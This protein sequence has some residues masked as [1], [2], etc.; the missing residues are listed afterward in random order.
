MEENMA[1]MIADLSGYTALTDTHGAHRAADIVDEFLS[2]VYQNLDGESILHEHSGDEVM[3]VSYSPDDLLKTA[4]QILLQ[5][6]I[7]QFP[8][9]HAGLHFG[10]VLKRN[11]RYFGTTINLAS[12]I[13]SQAEPG[14]LWSSLA[15]VSVIRDADIFEP[16]GNR[17]LKN[18][19]ELF[20]LFQYSPNSPVKNYVDPVCK[21]QVSNNGKSIPHPHDDSIFFCGHNCL[22]IFL[23]R[24]ETAIMMV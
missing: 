23:S 2:L 8:L 17:Q 15:F 5:S 18:L 3:V 20:Q 4:K 11:N 12:R 19:R 1:I 7:D 6:S 9:I 16:A 10:P 14:T 24:H 22:E 21:M 13:A